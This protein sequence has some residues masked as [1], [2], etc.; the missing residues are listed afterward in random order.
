[1]TQHVGIV[2]AGLVGCLAA[3]AFTSRGYDVTL[4]EYRED[5][6]LQTTK[7][8]NLR[9]I[10]LAVSSRGIS[11]LN[12]VDN[13]VAQQIIDDMIPM[14]GRMVH[15]VAGH[16]ESFLYGL[17]GETINSISREKLNISLLNEL[18]VKSCGSTRILFGHKLVDIRIDDVTPQ[19]SCTCLVDNKKIDL[20]FDFIVGCDG[21]FSKTRTQLQRSIRMNIEQEYMNCFY[22]ELYIPPT[23]NF[24]PEFGGKYALSPHYLHIWPHD[25]FMLIALPNTDG[26][27][28][29]TFFGP[30]SLLNSELTDANNIS[31]FLLK[32]FPD[33]ME[34][35]GI[36]NAVSRFLDNPK[37]SLVSINCY[38]YHNDSGK[39][40]LLGD[41]AHSMVPFFGQGMNCGFED[42]KVLMQLL[43]RC[44]GDRVE[45]FRLYTETRHKD[46]LSIVKLAKR[47]YK[48]MAHD[49]KS[50][51]FF[52][53]KQLDCVL[54]AVFKEKWLPLYTMV[55]F[56]PDIPYHVAEE[57]EERQRKILRYLQAVI[58]G[59]AITAGIA[60]VT[61][62]IHHPFHH[63]T[64]HPLH[65]FL[66]NLTPPK[67]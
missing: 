21:C 67:K 58:T 33:A 43:D 10:N 15:N 27:F 52:I 65:F 31:S 48:E 16:E 55:T 57:T 5:P 51:S 1:M 35:M 26:S 4:L 14:K 38:P 44:R 54:S 30:W 49:V 8:K 40:I 11:A 25:D 64:R 12:Y 59:S 28:T 66:N 50:W 19:A 13:T 46:L 7:D 24:N 37:E 22:L 41:A 53:R 29:S 60:F 42:V 36:E 34:I 20:V 45:A 32:H 18:E 62:V 47:N 23:D 6:R 56:R 17:N 63:F 39:L 2:G 9:S 3:L 61:H